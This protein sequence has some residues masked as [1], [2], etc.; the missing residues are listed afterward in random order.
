MTTFVWPI[1]VYY[2]DSDAGGVVYHSQYLNFMERARTEFLRHYGFVQTVLR[3]ELGIIFVVR[4]INIQYRKPAYFDDTLQVVST[5][6]NLGRSL[7]VFTQEIRRGEELL[8]E[9]QVE[10]VC[11]DAQKFKP[12]SIPAVIRDSIQRV[13]PENT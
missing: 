10:V 9:A 2:E 1:Q 5:L 7:M 8:I 12:V 13:N 11:V 6:T 3:E 4:N